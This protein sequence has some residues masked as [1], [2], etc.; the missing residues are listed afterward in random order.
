MK[1]KS[2]TH[3]PILEDGYVKGVFSE[4][5]IFS[6]IIR[7]KIIEIDESTKFSEY[8]EFLPPEKHQTETIVFEP[9]NM[10][11]TELNIV[12]AKARKN[13]ERIGMV[14]VTQK[15]KPNERLLGIITA[16]DL[17]EG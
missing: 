10:M 11:K 13:Q 4:N 14:L 17:P 15:G 3:I 16:W 7:D 2:F 12:F 8:E 6:S 9:K 1:E 5:T